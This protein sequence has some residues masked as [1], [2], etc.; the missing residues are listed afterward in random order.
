MA[1]EKKTGINM[2][3]LLAKELDLVAGFNENKAKKAQQS[4]GTML[5]LTTAVECAK[6][7]EKFRKVLA[8]R[9]PEFGVPTTRD[10][11][12]PVDAAPSA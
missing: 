9:F 12:V 5:E 8:A 7:A 1:T 6:R 11:A 2:P 10:A 3:S 4:G